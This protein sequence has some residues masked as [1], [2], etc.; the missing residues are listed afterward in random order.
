[1]KLMKH[2][3]EAAT[4]QL[5]SFSGYSPWI[6]LHFPGSLVTE[7]WWTIIPCIF[8]V[9][10]KQISELISTF[11]IH[12]AGY[13]QLRQAHKVP[14]LKKNS[15]S[16]VAIHLIYFHQS[17]WKYTVDDDSDGLSGK[18]TPLNYSM[19]L[20]L[21]LSSTAQHLH[22]R[23]PRICSSSELSHDIDILKTFIF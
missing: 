9:I 19:L 10:F 2:G 12:I 7:F 18:S 21:C 15:Y 20:F 11:G 17:R 4:I 14:F 6:I 22:H 1:M 8:S 3:A 13:F 23:K 16:L 5:R